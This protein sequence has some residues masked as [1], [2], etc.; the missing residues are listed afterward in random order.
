[1]KVIE[2]FVIDAATPATFTR[3]GTAWYWD[4]AGTLQSAGTN[5]L[6]FHW[7]K[8][9]GSYL[10]VLIEGAA[11]NILLNN[12]TLST[13]TRTVSNSTTYTLSFY[14]TGTVTLS[15]AAS[16][17]TTGTAANVR[18]TR[19]F[20]TSS[21]SL[22]LTVSGSVTYAQLETGGIATSVIITAG[23][24]VTR[25]ADVVTGTGMFYTGYTD[26][27][28]AYNAGTAY[29][30]ADVI[31]YG[32]RLYESLQAANTGH[33][34]DASPTWWLDT[35]PTN[36]TAPFDGQV[37]TVAAGG[38]QEETICIK[39][40][41]PANAFGLFGLE[42]VSYLH[43]I[44]STGGMTGQGS[45]YKS[46]NP[47]MAVL[48]DDFGGSYYLTVTVNSGS[49]VVF[50]GIGEIVVGYMREIGET[51]YG[52]GLG[53]IDYS[54][55]DTDEFGVTTFVERPY[56]KRMSVNVKVDKAD[57]NTMTELMFT[58]RATPT[59]WIPSDDTDYSSAI[60]YGFIR[61]FRAV[62]AYKTASLYSLEIEGL[63]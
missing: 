55:K 50:P 49:G 7:D 5:V 63:T 41:T 53:L 29:A 17:A 61:D 3:A 52:T 30:L 6:R 23:A 19:T 34:P 36:N 39:T 35:G 4:Y 27:T 62:I 38:S 21:T 57:F 33:T 58:L 51:E 28:P 14:G 9:G 8:N 26:A 42:N 11:T 16:G 43:G 2:P 44:I 13:Q 45:L 40:A 15:G 24:A 37:G 1:M 18:T 20:A 12:A 47:T 32:G 25:P 22:T 59:A 10:G 56:A 48:E 60:V 31:Q 54:R 46:G